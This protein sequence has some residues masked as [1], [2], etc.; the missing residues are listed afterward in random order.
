MMASDH[1]SRRSFLKGASLGTVGA[2][3]AGAMSAY[4]TADKKAD[5]LAALGGSPLRTTPFPRWP[6]AT[7]EVEQSLVSA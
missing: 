4:G 2:V 6:P 3:T 1:V 5:G 7:A